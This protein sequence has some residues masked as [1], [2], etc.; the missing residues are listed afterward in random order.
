M[1]KSMVARATSSD[2]SPT[3]AYLYVEIA[4]MTHANFEG[5]RQLEAYLLSRIKKSN[6][7]IKYKCLQIIK[8]VCLKGR[9]DFKAAMRRESEAVK[10]CLNF[11]G[12]P[13]PLRGE[14]IYRR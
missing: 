7:N 12:K 4:A 14:E 6:H 1:D 3:P 10:E 5:S 9:S 2:D 13:D 11:T 8:N